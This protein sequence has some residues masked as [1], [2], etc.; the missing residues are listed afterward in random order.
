MCNGADYYIYFM[1]P[2]AIKDNYYMALLSCLPI[3]Q[4]KRSYIHKKKQIYIH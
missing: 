3:T 4:F 2:Q 1:S